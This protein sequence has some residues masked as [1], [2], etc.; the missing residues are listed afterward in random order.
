MTEV[1]GYRYRI[2]SEIGSG[3]MGAVFRAQDMHS[4]E[5]VALKRV[6][7]DVQSLGDGTT[8][9][10]RSYRVA[11]AQEFKTLA[12]L[13]HPNIIGVRDYG[14][15]TGG[16]PYFTMDLLENA[17]TILDAGRGRNMHVQI[18]YV[19]QMLNALV[20]LHRRNI[21]HRDL[22]PENVLVVDG[23]VKVLDF[24]LSVVKRQKKRDTAETAI[25]GTLAYMAPELLYEQ[26]ASESSDLYAVGIITY[27]MMSGMHPFDTENMSTLLH[28]IVNDYPDLSLIDAEYPIVRF[29][30]TLMEK[31][32][33]NRIRDASL[34]LK[35]LNEAARI[36]LP[37]ETEA[38]RESF[39]QTA[40][41]IG[42]DK[43]LASLTAGLERTIDGQGN[44]WLVGGESGVGKSRLLDE[45]RIRAMVRGMLVLRGQA[46]N[47]SG[48]IFDVWQSILS[49]L[50]LI[51]ERRASTLASLLP[52]SQNNE[53]VNISADVIQTRVLKLIIDTIEHIQQ[54]VMIAFEDL[55]WAGTESIALLNLLK[56]QIN[57]L[58]IFVVGTY[59]DDEAT[60]MRQQ[61]G[62][63]EHMRLGRLSPESIAEISHDMLGDV[64]ERPQVVDLL[65]RETE[66][67]VYFLIEVVRTLAEE[68]GNLEHIG[69]TTL[70]QHVFSG[71]MQR[72]IQRRI[73]QVPLNARDLLYTA[74][75]LG[76]QLDVR[77]LGRIAP[78]MDMGWWLVVCS[79]AAII[80]VEN[81]QWRFAHD[82][83]REE[84][85]KRIPHPARLALHEQIATAMEDLYGNSREHMVALVYHWRMA[86]NPARE[87]SYSVQAAELSVQ[88][89]AYREAIRFMTR[90]LALSESEEPPDVQKQINYRRIRATAHLGVGEYT[91]AEQLYRDHL[92]V[93][94]QRQHIPGIAQDLANLGQVMTVLEQFDEARA[95]HE[96]SL[97]YYREL[98]DDEGI[99][100]ALNRLGDI[101]YEFG[102]QT[103]ARTL[104]QESLELSR[105]IGS[106]W[107]SAGTS[108]RT[109]D[110]PTDEQIAA[111]KQ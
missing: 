10:D 74:A 14:F 80:H 41:L 62:D 100:G 68:A 15:D 109:D 75:A 12:A 25:A 47:E 18:G 27:E 42:R 110:K 19:A 56:L 35:S 98:K 54:P 97:G 101:E 86:E 72:I 78:D 50:D 95:Y 43:E 17:Q 11:M 5:H 55:Q 59:R 26:E 23:E 9:D 51:G 16:Q 30:G 3:G 65:Q 102:N 28:Q 7:P 88:T 52:D 31:S 87:E 64:G 84:I 34:A 63:V 94:Q 105:Q 6:V 4:G 67:N 99:I 81:E 49:W 66:G 33:E 57:R 90:T 38:I 21:I 108:A 2:I 103:R 89:G 82:K 83:I 32:P 44:M 91:Q 22:K 106:G 8:S 13:R 60:D 92:R 20:Y 71:G 77:L 1:V 79:D 48:G 104:Y 24:G 58:P 69:L 53:P 39:L 111:Y 29:I 93:N 107:G 37:A 96:E 40:R 73:S 45:I 36:D 61:L 76:R 85:L 70:P 46:R